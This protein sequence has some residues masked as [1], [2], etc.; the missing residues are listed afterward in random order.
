MNTFFHRVLEPTNKGAEL[1]RSYIGLIHGNQMTHYFMFSL[2]PPNEK[3]EEEIF[4][5]S[6]GIS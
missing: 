3:P 1:R 6:E 2:P 4:N 5:G